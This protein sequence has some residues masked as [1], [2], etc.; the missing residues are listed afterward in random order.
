MSWRCSHAGHEPEPIDQTCRYGCGRRIQDTF[1]RH[2]CGRCSRT[3]WLAQ[4][5][6]WV[7]MCPDYINT[8]RIL[9]ELD[10]EQYIG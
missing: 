4:G 7:L 10:E 1:N 6:V 5:A 2:D 3:D 8:L 9:R